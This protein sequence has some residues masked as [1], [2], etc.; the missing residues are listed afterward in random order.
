VRNTISRHRSGP[1]SSI[2]GYYYNSGFAWDPDNRLRQ[3]PYFLLNAALEW[4]LPGDAISIRAGGT[5]LNDAHTC[6]YA[7]A[8]ALGDICSPRAPRLVSLDVTA[9]F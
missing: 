9:R 7:S 8:T 1:S 3:A 6:V 5:N 4:T 2:V